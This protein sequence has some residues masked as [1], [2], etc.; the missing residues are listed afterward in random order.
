MRK[1][2]ETLDATV[3]WDG[4]SRTITAHKEDTTVVMQLDN[5]YMTV[6]DIPVYL[7]SPPV[8]I[9]DRTL[10]PL[11]AVSEAFDVGVEWD[12]ST[13]TAV[14]TSAVNLYLTLANKTSVSIGQ[15]ASGLARP[16]RTEISVN[17]YLWY[18]YN[19]DYS[20]FVMVA[21]DGG[22]VC[23]F[24]TNSKGFRLSDGLQ[25][26]AASGGGYAAPGN[27]FVSAFT[28][29]HANDTV[30]AVLVIKDAPNPADE[31]SDSFLEIQSRENF[32]ALNAFRVNY[33]KN[34]LE[35]DEYAAEAARLHSRDMA[36]ND[37]FSHVSQDGRNPG[38]RYQAVKRQYTP[39]AW[40]ENIVAGR[41]YG[42]QAIDGWINSKGHRDNMLKD[43]YANVGVGAGYDSGSGYGYY[44]T[45]LFSGS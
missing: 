24:Y 9:D 8:L 34:V 28:V 1:I 35:W 20:N 41:K 3:E 40:G 11:R 2:F 4:I 16:D 36:D 6:D 19:S 30:H 23:G 18:I 10:I 27:I 14:L 25:Y 13:R 38:D 31:V 12:A 7:E 22:R 15:A 45:Q 21:V 43:G 32:D 26:G 44:M 33:G 17:G 37:Y 39:T 42:I 29:K 5:N